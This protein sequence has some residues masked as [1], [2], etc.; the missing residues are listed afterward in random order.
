MIY[1]SNMVERII[2]E[3]FVTWIKLK[4]RLHVTDI[5]FYFHEREIWWASLG[6]NIGYEQD[7]KNEKFERPV[8]V[9]KKFNSHLLWILPL[10][11]TIKEHKYYFKTMHENREYCIILSQIR[12]ISSKRL[13]RKIRTLPIDEFKSVK[14]HIKQIL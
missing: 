3:R 5:D 13:L 9:L 8:L 12:T 4:V 10:T 11:S 1:F 6:A 14:E 7:G 2:L